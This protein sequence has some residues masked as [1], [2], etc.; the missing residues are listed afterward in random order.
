MEMK[1]RILLAVMWLVLMT[2]TRLVQ[3][4]SLVVSLLLCVFVYGIKVWLNVIMQCYAQ[5]LLE[6]VSS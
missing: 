1:R 5:E 6:F 4:L 2:V 3:L